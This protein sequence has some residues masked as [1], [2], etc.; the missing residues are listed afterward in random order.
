MHGTFF[1]YGTSSTTLSTPP[2]ISNWNTSIVT[3]MGNM[4]NR[5]GYASTTLN[6]PPDVSK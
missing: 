2:D 1:S 6:T 3:D 4:F 5:Y